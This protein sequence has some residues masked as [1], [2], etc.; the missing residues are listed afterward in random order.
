VKNWT[1]TIAVLVAI[2][3]QIGGLIGLPITPDITD[4]LQQAALFIV[5]LFT[6]VQ[7]IN[8]SPENVT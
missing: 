8:P 4:A 1:T 6:G 5:G 7:V 2:G 3:A